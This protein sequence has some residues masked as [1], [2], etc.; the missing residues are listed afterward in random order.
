VW[1]RATLPRVRYDQ[2]MELGWKWLL[3]LALLNLVVTPVMIVLLPDMAAHTIALFIFGVVVLFAV[4]AFGRSKLTA[5]GK[6][7]RMVQIAP[8]SRKAGP[9]G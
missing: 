3:P 8:A 9:E 2:L 4:N 6:R 5:P 1:L 7:V